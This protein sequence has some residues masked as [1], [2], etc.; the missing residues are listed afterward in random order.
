MQILVLSGSRNRQGKT[1]QAIGIICKGVENADVRPYRSMVGW[2]SRF[3]DQCL[4][5]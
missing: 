3:P 1:A 2:P 5:L 4:Y